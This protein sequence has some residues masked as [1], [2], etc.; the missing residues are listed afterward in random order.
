M[1]T[2]TQTP[3]RLI[4]EVATKPVLPRHIKLR[5]DKGRDVW[6]LLAP[7]RVFT[8]DPIAVEVLKLCDGARTVDDIA[9]V[10]AVEY[11]APR[12]TIRGDIIAMLQD[13]ADKGVV[14]S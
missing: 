14:K 4:V 5:H 8:P 10:L 6:V 11:Q 7:E 12:D 1:S 13:L 2:T 3:K 9:G